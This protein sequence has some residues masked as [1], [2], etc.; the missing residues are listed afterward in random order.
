MKTS[1]KIQWG[2]ITIYLI[3]SI[4]IG[5]ILISLLQ[6]SIVLKNS[7][8][9]YINYS[10]TVGNPDFDVKNVTLTLYFDFHNLGIYDIEARKVHAKIFI[11][12]SQNETALPPN[13]L[14]GKADLFYYFPARMITNQTFNITLIKYYLDY[15][16]LYWAHL[17]FDLASYRSNLAGIQFD[18]QTNITYF[19]NFT[20]FFPGHAIHS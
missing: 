13:T 19:W 17:R 5:S 3:L 18:F 2:I 4:Y 7:Y 10:G 15:L 20:A 8:S 1:S 14:I 11:Q 16:V 12:D 6:V 9:G